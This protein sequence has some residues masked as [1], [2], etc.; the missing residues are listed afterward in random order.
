MKNDQKNPLYPSV[1]VSCMIKQVNLLFYPEQD[2]A[3]IGPFINLEFESLIQNSPNPSGLSC[4]SPI[5][6]FCHVSCMHHIVAL[7]WC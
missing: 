5:H 7:A 2:N 4:T 1:L 3:L 6:P